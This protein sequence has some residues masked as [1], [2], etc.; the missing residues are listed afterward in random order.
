MSHVNAHPFTYTDRA[1]W[2]PGMSDEQ[3]ALLARRD[4]ELEDYLAELR[5]G[6]IGV[7]NALDAGVTLSGTSANDVLS[8]TFTTLTRD[9]TLTI[10]AVFGVTIAGG[11]SVVVTASAQ[12]D[13]ATILPVWPLAPETN[14]WAAAITP[15]YEVD[16]GA[17]PGRTAL[18]YHLPHINVA[19][20]GE[21]TILLQAAK[22][23]GA[24][25]VTIQ[26]GA[27]MVHGTWV[28]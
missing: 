17:Q 21:H 5:R 10:D 8:V 3:R 11:T 6:A 4:A 7:S 13:A 22:N 15:Q 20:P 28:P 16:G 26:A 12:L 14:N 1:E 23:A 27:T 25:T 2:L 9:A 24:A 18:P 19:E